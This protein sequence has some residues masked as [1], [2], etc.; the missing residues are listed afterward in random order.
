MLLC[1]WRQRS[2]IHLRV[3]IEKQDVNYLNVNQQCWKG[4]LRLT[5]WIHPCKLA[6]M[7]LLGLA[8]EFS[9]CCTAQVQFIPFSPIVLTHILELNSG[10]L[11]FSP[12]FTVKHVKTA[13]EVCPALSLPA[14]ETL[15][16]VWVRWWQVNA[17]SE[18]FLKTSLSWEK[19]FM[20]PIC[21]VFIHSL[22]AGEWVNSMIFK[23]KCI[24]KVL[25]FL[26]CSPEVV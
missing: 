6:G 11:F 5:V 10:L 17:K 22:E 26:L 2:F 14:V 15:H 13:A 18:G 20:H 25:G 8:L 23:D 12:R 1:L 4:S 21:F 3:S 9:M 24:F 19:Q 7:C 16:P